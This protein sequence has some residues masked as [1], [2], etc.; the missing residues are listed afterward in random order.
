MGMVSCDLTQ[1]VAL[2]ADGGCIRKN[3]SPFGG[4]WAWCGVSAAG[5]RI[6]ERGGVVEAK[7]GQ[8]ITNNHMEQIAITLAL[9][10]MP[11][12][13]SGRVLSDSQVAL[14]RVFRGWARRNL[15]RNVS[16][17]SA[18]AVKRLGRIETV[19]LQG[20]PTRADLEAGTGKKRGLPVS[21][22]NVWCDGECSRRAA[23][24]MAEAFPA[25]ETLP[26]IH[27]AEASPAGA[28]CKGCGSTTAETAFN[29]RI[30]A[31]RVCVE[32]ELDDERTTGACWPCLDFTPEGKRLKPLSARRR[33]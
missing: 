1:V 19:L 18:R 15:P 23:L 32:C 25:T 4:T 12:G 16:E 22:H 5:E 31:E 3:P 2:Y 6:I 21:E 20:H 28:K 13:W 26:A 17:R 29:C 8:F 33:Y 30:C 7:P 24:F 9:E 14:G 10:A 27:T 11:E